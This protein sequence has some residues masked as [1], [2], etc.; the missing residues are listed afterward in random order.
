MISAP[1]LPAGWH[2][3]SPFSSCDRSPAG[4]Q[5]NASAQWATGWMGKG[6]LVVFSAVLKLCLDDWA[7]P[8]FGWIA[9]VS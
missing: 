6:R 3:H 2:A 8:S 7:M 4:L 9:V 5:P 1:D